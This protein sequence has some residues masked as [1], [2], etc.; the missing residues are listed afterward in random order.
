M[1]QLLEYK[2]NKGQ[3]DRSY[4]TDQ[5]V[6]FTHFRV[7]GFRTSLVPCNKEDDM[8]GSESDLGEKLLWQ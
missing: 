4:N 1:N 7:M 5:V 3:K 6:T 2:K 8:G